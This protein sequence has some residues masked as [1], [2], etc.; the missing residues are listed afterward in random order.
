MKIN[1]D[2]S[3]YSIELQ[4]FDCLFS[5]RQS[6]QQDNKSDWQI[7][8]NSGH[9][10]DIDFNISLINIFEPR[11]DINPDDYDL[12][13][14]A[15]LSEPL[16][17]FNQGY[18]D[19]LN[20][21]QTYIVCNSFL[22]SN[23][24]MSN[25]VIWFPYC[26]IIQCTDWWHRSFFPMPY[27]NTKYAH[28][29]RQN[30]IVAINGRNRVNRNY[31]FA[32][33]KQLDCNVKILSNINLTVNKLQDANWE[34]EQDTEF[35]IWLNS[36]YKGQFVS[37]SQTKIKYYDNA[38]SIGI[39]EK[40]GT[41]PIGYWIM[42]EYF[43]NACVI[44]PESCWLNNELSMTEKVA[45]CFLAG[46][47]PFPVAGSNVN[48]LYNLLGFSTAWNLLPKQLQEFDLEKNHVKRYQGAIEAILWLNNNM[49]IFTTVECQN[50]LLKNK[51]NFITNSLATSVME[52][53]CSV[54][55]K[56][57]NIKLQKRLT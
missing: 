16:S 18:L 26:V 54:I 53:I 30:Q 48:R 47:M 24:A 31:F 39:D 22:D 40:F 3:D 37:N 4:M 49:D 29:A 9:T 23:H 11:R 55:K 38:R 1:V 17:V 13:L 44:F 20:L 57:S 33:L 45:K 36:N 10:G 2:Y 12:I 50:M 6:L 21:E 28:F 43:E 5:Y 41:I 25:K 32:L 42:P 52:K 14:L 35:R 7:Q 19:L 27:Q 15:N 8:F 46:S 51:L 34:S 56:R